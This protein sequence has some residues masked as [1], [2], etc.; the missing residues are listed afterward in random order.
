MNDPH[1]Q[2]PEFI[3]GYLTG[4]D[5]AFST[6]QSQVLDIQP[7]VS[8]RSLGLDALLT[9]TEAQ[10]FRIARMTEEKSRAM[11]CGHHAGCLIEVQPG[12]KV[13]AA[14]EERHASNH[15][16]AL[17]FVLNLLADPAAVNVVKGSLPSAVFVSDLDHCRVVTN[18]AA[19]VR[20][21]AGALEEDPL[22]TA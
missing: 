5:A 13:C 10:A 6:F 7:T 9:M 21:V 18:L 4:L 20:K 17:D 3:K 11:R 19:Y 2:S 14:C 16:H 1:Q 15:T 22:E 12:R 8:L